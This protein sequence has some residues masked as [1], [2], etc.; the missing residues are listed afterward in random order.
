MGMSSFSIGRR[1]KYIFIALVI[2][3]MIFCGWKMSTLKIG[4]STPGSPILWDY[5]TYNRDQALINHLFGASSENFVLYYEGSKESVYDPIVLK[6][7]EEFSFHMSERLPDIY[8]SSNSIIDMART[9]NLVQHDGDPVWY[10]LPTD[11]ERMTGLLGYIRSTVG[12]LTLARYLDLDLERSQVT[13][14]FADHTSDNLLRI[15]DAAYDFFKN[16]HPMKTDKGEFKLAGGR[17]GM[18]LAL[19]EEMKRAHGIIDATV[20]LAIFILC[21]LSFMSITAG[22]MLTLPLIL[23]N[24]VAGS[25][26]ALTNIGLSVNTL[27]IAAIG[28]GVGVDFAIYL[29]ARCIEEFPRYG[30]DWNA[31]ILQSVCTC[32][33]AVVYTG[34]T[35]IVPI[36]TWYFFSDM[37]FQ[38]QVGFFLAMIMGTNVILT[39]TL[40]P[41]MIYLIKPKF[42]SGKKVLVA[43]AKEISM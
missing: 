16:H 43:E 35:I 20:L 18:E 41:L 15:R 11:N 14:Y 3:G 29:Y 13:L 25:Y 38:A 24:S 37:R 22:L 23:A 39:L 36:L 7:F 42:I 8:K 21:A 5:H 31:L 27:P 30:G 34:L 17:I 33:K 19:N 4:D 12:M 40:H 6:T 32:G 9:L 2:G 1:S 28:V 26:M 10:S